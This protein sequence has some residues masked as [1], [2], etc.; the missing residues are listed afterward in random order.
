M[1]WN[2][3]WT[4]IFLTCTRGLIIRLSFCCCWS[5]SSISHCFFFLIWIF[6][7]F[8]IWRFPFSNWNRKL[9]KISCEKV[10][11]LF[12]ILCVLTRTKTLMHTF[13]STFGSSHSTT[14]WEIKPNSSEKHLK[15]L[16]QREFKPI[17]Y[18]RQH[19]WEARK[20]NHD[21]I[22]MATFSIFQKIGTE[23]DVVLGSYL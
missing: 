21:W 2:P 4:S 14:A 6:S 23:I 19:Y 17:V 9:E 16:Y 5:S 18:Y 7:F 13:S 10:G 22:A 1:S 11:T 3:F 8:L 12:K 20:L 15:V